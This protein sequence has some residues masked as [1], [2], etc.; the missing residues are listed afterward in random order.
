[1]KIDMVLQQ[2]KDDDYKRMEKENLYN[3]K[4]E[5]YR[6]YADNNYVPKILDRYGYKLDNARN[7]VPTDELMMNIDDEIKDV[8][9]RITKASSNEKKSKLKIYVSNLEILKGR[10]EDE[11]IQYQTGLSKKET[12][13]FE[14]EQYYKDLTAKGNDEFAKYKEQ[15]NAGNVVDEMDGSRKSVSELTINIDKEIKGKVEMAGKLNRRNDKQKIENIYKHVASLDKLKKRIINDQ[16]TYEYKLNEKI[17]ST[18]PFEV[19]KNFQK[20]IKTGNEELGKYQK[21]Y[22]ESQKAEKKN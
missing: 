20:L 10:I 16:N 21:Q 14:V 22:E 13:T 17:R 3:A 9:S 18:S 5:E 15:M 1:M 2:G 12:S 11:K 19:W 4:P 7:K 8:N 6:A